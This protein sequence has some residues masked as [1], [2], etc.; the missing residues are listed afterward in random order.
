MTDKKSMVEDGAADVGSLKKD[1]LIKKAESVGVEVKSSMNKSELVEAIEEAEGS[2]DGSTPENPR[3]DGSYGTPKDDPTAGQGVKDFEA[4]Q[5][6]PQNEFTD[7][8]KAAANAI[9]ANT[10]SDR[11][12]LVQP[13]VPDRLPPDSATAARAVEAVGRVIEDENPGLKVAP[14]PTGRVLT[15]GTKL[16]FHDEEVVLQADVMVTYPGWQNDAKFAGLKE[17]TGN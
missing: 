4:E 1:E 8:V 17:L 11:A 2:D 10:I 9:A 12:D 7:P 14:D 15:K 3:P 13:E 6:K 5:N 16:K